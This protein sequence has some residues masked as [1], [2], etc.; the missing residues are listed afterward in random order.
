MTDAERLEIG[1]NG[2]QYF[3]EHFDLDVLTGQLIKHFHEVSEYIKG[4]Q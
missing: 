3:K 1:E 4:K 2:R